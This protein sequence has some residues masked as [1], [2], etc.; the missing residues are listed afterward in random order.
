MIKG[1]NE[2][3]SA[4]NGTFDVPGLSDAEWT[5][6]IAVRV[7]RLPQCTLGDLAAFGR[8]ERR[9]VMYNGAK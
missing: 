7:D 2:T 6:G 9:G 8:K 5:G 4:E 1:E 3:K